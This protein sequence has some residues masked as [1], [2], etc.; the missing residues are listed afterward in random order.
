MESLQSKLT[1]ESLS[2]WDY[3]RSSLE[4]AFGL[5]YIADDGE[6]DQMPDNDA[7]AKKVKK[8]LIAIAKGIDS[9]KEA[10]SVMILPSNSP[11]QPGIY[12]E[13]LSPPLTAS[14]EIFSYCGDSS[15]S[16]SATGGPIIPVRYANRDNFHLAA[17]MMMILM[18]SDSSAKNSLYIEADSVD[19][20]GK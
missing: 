5:T 9:N 8:L 14:S 4:E 2:P 16:E 18:K 10:C 7:A 11:E 1:I 15:S 19:D 12:L 13:I 20:I 3:S 17:A 6:T